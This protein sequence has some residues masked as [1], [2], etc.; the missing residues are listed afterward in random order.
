MSRNGI[1]QST[2]VSFADDGI[3]RFVCIQVEMKYG[4]SQNIIVL[5]LSYIPMA[6]FTTDKSG[7]YRNILVFVQ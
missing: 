3:N 5:T 2:N 6:L 7:V 1:P 4:S